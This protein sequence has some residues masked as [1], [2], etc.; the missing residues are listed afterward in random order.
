MTAFV[1]HAPIVAPATATATAAA[2]RV[3]CT[4]P[5]HAQVARITLSRPEVRNA[6]NDAVIAELT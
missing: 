1:S 3:E 2:L 6:F 4:G 5:A